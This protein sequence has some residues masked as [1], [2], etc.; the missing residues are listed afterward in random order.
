[1]RTNPV[2][3]VDEYIKTFPAPVQK[4]LRS[5]RATIRK[6]IPDAEEVIKYGIP[7][8]VLNKKNLIHFAAYKSHIGLYP[9]PSGNAVFQSALVPY[10]SGKSTLQF[11]LDQPL[12]LELISKLVQFRLVD[13]LG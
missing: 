1:M 13:R 9:V 12:P 2:A 4:Q 7:T 10:K 3:N 6:Q 8:F 11:P 5:M